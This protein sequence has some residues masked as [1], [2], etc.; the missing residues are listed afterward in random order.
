MEK[1]ITGGTPFCGAAI[2]IL[3]L[4]ARY[5]LMCGNMAHAASFDFP[6]RY[7][8]V[9]LPTGW[10]QDLNEAK[11][12]A[13][14][15]AAKELEAEGVRAITTGCGLFAVWQKRAAEELG[16]PIFT[17]PLLM[18]PVISKM[19]GTQ[20]KVGIITAAG[21]RLNEP[22]FLEACGIDENT[23]FLIGELDTCSEFMDCIR[24]QGK[25]EM[26]AVLFQRQVVQLS[27]DMIDL[28]PAVGAFLLECSDIP[29]FAAAI[30]KETGLP[31]FD[32]V[33]LTDMLYRAL[34]PKKY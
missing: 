34:M 14:I 29:P 6:V 32:F 15:G 8:V 4:N 31:V 26:D 18:T 24:Y 12:Q 5:P 2:G 11:Y 9:D 21:K 28:D 3:V 27:K 19:I 33:S 7:K 13:F 16:I 1:T 23:P 30:S 22:H 20:K 17:S 25:K 10:W